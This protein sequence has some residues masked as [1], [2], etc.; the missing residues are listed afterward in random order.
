MGQ[1]SE[2]Q[3]GDQQNE[4]T[5]HSGGCHSCFSGLAVAWPL[6]LFYHAPP[7]AL[8]TLLCGAHLLS[9]FGRIL[10]GPSSRAPPR[11]QPPCR[12]GSLALRIRHPRA[13][14]RLAVRSTRLGSAAAPGGPPPSVSLGFGAGPPR[15]SAVPRGGDWPTPHTRA[16]GQLTLLRSPLAAEPL[17]LGGPAPALGEGLRGKAHQLDW[18][19]WALART[20]RMTALPPLCAKTRLLTKRCRGLASS[21]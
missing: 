21:L 18:K 7:A 20:K 12:A 11:G 10:G 15:F 16:N 3:L 2:C 9:P 4:R 6:P 17:L 14:R 1:N 8:P 13:R 5:S 19:G